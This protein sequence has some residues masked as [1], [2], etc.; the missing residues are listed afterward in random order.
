MTDGFNLDAGIESELQRLVW[1]NWGVAAQ[2]VEVFAALR[3]QVVKESLDKV[4]SSVDQVDG[5]QMTWTQLPDGLSWKGTGRHE[6]TRTTLGSI[7]CWF[8]GENGYL[9]AKVQSDLPQTLILGYSLL[10][11]KD[12]VWGKW[13]ENAS[14]FTAGDIVEN[15]GRNGLVQRSIK[16]PSAE[17]GLPLAGFYEL[18]T[19]AVATHMILFRWWAEKINGSSANQ[20]GSPTGAVV[21]DMGKSDSP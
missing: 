5:V 12:I 13:R 11:A 20:A 16:A 17:K 9:E 6:S 19:D 2:L 10:E 1:N 4:Q 8:T 21:T 14:S 18:I 3:K 15:L 7:T